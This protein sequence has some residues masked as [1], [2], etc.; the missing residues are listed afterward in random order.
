[1][2]PAP[3]RAAGCP[4]SHSHTPIGDCAYAASSPPSHLPSAHAP[5]LPRPPRACAPLS[6]ARRLLRLGR[7]R[8]QFITPRHFGEPQWHAIFSR[9]TANL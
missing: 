5:M 9:S 3:A 2:S 1:M 8:G 7:R 6:A 4:L